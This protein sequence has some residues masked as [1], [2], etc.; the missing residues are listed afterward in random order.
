MTPTRLPLALVLSLA[1]MLGA[2]ASDPSTSSPDGGAYNPCDAGQQWCRNTCY[3]VLH[4]DHCGGR[5]TRC[6]WRSPTG[7]WGE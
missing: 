2:C 7:G 3:P 5:V 4:R 1:A 6:R